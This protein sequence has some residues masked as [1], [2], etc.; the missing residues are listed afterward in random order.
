MGAHGCRLTHALAAQGASARPAKAPPSRR[1]ACAT[2][3]RGGARQNH[4]PCAPCRAN[5]VWPSLCTRRRRPAA[6]APTGAAQLAWT[7]ARV[8]RGNWVAQRPDVIPS[9]PASIL[10]R[11]P[12]AR[13]PC[14]PSRPHA[15]MPSRRV[16]PSHGSAPGRR[17]RCTQAPRPSRT[18]RAQLLDRRCHPAARPSWACTL[19]S[20][21]TSWPSG[22][23][24]SLEQA[25]RGPWQRCMAAFVCVRRRMRVACGCGRADA[26]SL[27][28]RRTPHAARRVAGSAGESCRRHRPA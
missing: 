9:C 22:P 17:A 19:S 10:Q 20:A 4:R 23:S 16:R 6:E 24:S 12:R 21:A 8:G 7:G 27:L 18:H 15:L 3:R 2:C 1:R 28:L 5:R 25:W 14:L 13:M 11:P 26:R